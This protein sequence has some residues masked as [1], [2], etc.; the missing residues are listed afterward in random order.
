MLLSCPLDSLYIA[1]MEYPY[2]L[3]HVAR[4]AARETIEQ[5]IHIYLL[6]TSMTCP[7]SILYSR[8][9]I[10]TVPLFIWCDCYDLCDDLYPSR[11]MPLDPANNS[12]RLQRHLRRERDPCD[13]QA[14][15]RGK[16]SIS[17]SDSI[18]YLSWH[19][20]PCSRS[21]RFT[22]GAKATASEDRPMS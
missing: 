21:V 5:T 18:H 8:S 16:D 3:S 13:E 12:N 9:A 1:T 17:P 15:L 6:Y 7:L 20:I 22:P 14:H 2:V 11:L 4:H 10:Y 19:L